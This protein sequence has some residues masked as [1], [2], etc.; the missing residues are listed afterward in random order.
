MR[1]L[2]LILAATAGLGLLSGAAAV[3][4]LA[5][6]S[7]YF[8]T[9]N[10]YT[11]HYQPYGYYSRPYYAPYY[12]RYNEPRYNRNGHQYYNYYSNPYHRY[13]GHFGR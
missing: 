5:Q 6:V 13:P 4:A 11:P 2:S 7:L 1:K 9:P 8:G 3:P 10:Y 12:Q